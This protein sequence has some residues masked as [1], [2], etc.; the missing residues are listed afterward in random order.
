M[1]QHSQDS[2]D[3]ACWTVPRRACGISTFPST[4]PGEMMQDFLIDHSLIISAFR[5]SASKQ[6][7]Q[8]HLG[9][10]VCPAAICTHRSAQQQSGLTGLP[11]SNLDSQVRPAA[12]RTHRFA[13]MTVLIFSWPLNL[14]LNG[15]EQRRHVYER[16]PMLAS[17]PA[18]T[19]M[20][21]LCSKLALRCNHEQCWLIDQE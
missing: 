15:I 7:A 6:N 20:V 14:T 16:Q 19:D 9:S 4:S 18:I 10:R 12:S 17:P 13:I 11:S 1:A 21:T 5:S 8:Q 2:T 3:L